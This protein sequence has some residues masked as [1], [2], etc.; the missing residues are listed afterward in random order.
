MKQFKNN[1]FDFTINPLP[2]FLNLLSILTIIGCCVEFYNTINDYYTKDIEEEVSTLSNFFP[3]QDTTQFVDEVN[4]YKDVL[5]ITDIIGI[6][7]CLIGAF[8]MRKLKKIGFQFWLFGELFPTIVTII[9]INS[10]FESPYPY[11]FVFPLLFIIAY[12]FQ[13]RFLIN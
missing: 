4:K 12:F 8:Q 13:R 10:F 1:D 11:F 6:I 5:F 9:L 7:F 2:S 3:N